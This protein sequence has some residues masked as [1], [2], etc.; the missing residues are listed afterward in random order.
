MFAAKAEGDIL[1]GMKDQFRCCIATLGD[2]AAANS[3]IYP[4][5]FG[6]LLIWLGGLVSSV[7]SHVTFAGDNNSRTP[8]VAVLCLHR[9]CVVCWLASE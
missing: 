1:R 9:H 7:R 6:T 4:S 2:G 3:D 8:A 5:L